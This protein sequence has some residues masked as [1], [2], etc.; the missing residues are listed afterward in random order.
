MCSFEDPDS[1][2]FLGDDWFKGGGSLKLESSYFCE[3]GDHA[4]IR[5]P[6]IKTSGV[7]IARVPRKIRINSAHANWGPCFQVRSC[8]T[9]CSAP[10]RRELV[11]RVI[12]KHLPQPQRTHIQSFRTIRMN[13]KTDSIS[14][15]S[16]TWTGGRHSVWCGHCHILWCETQKI[17]YL[18][19]L[20][21]HP[22]K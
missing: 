21:F 12:L 8:G 14:P 4:K 17:S 16:S 2:Y 22:K 11:C 15:S 18:V 6:T 1:L 5:N 13:N 19:R 3:V 20:N 10:H 9:L 7:L